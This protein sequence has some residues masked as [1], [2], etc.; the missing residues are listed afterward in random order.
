MNGIKKFKPSLGK[1]TDKAYQIF[2]SLVLF[3]FGFWYIYENFLQ[4]LVTSAL[5]ISSYN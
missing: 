5:E 2:F 4:I 3:S 1:Y